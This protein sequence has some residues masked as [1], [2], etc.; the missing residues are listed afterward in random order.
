MGT[1]DKKAV[2]LIQYL[3]QYGIFCL[4]ILTPNRGKIAQP[5]TVVM[6][7]KIF[8]PKNG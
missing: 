5:G 3:G 6:A 1:S 2:K 7:L 4:L 8:L